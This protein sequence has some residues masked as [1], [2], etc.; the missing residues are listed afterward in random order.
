MNTEFLATVIG[1]YLVI[2]SLFVLL[3]HE[4]A[5]A[6]VADVLAQP[7][8]FFI[9]AL[10]TL[11]IGLMLVASH[12]VWVMGWPILVTIVAWLVL[13]SGLMRLVCA[14]SAMRLT[15]SFMDHP[16]RLK[17]VNFITLIVGL[18]ML[19]HAYYPYIEKYTH[20]VQ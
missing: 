9:V 1:W 10:I 17:V 3:K 6:V 14:D 20:V 5:K 8:L 18:F 15:R 4:H 12:N 16:V 13:L 7:G 2:V 11:I 19:V